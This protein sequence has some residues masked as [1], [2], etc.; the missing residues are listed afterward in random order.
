MSTQND[1]S[2]DSSNV[3]ENT[4][5]TDITCIGPK[6]ETAL[7]NMGVET[8]SDVAMLSGQ[9]MLENVASIAKRDV[10]AALMDAREMAGNDTKVT[11]TE[12]VDDAPSDAGVEV[13]ADIGSDDIMS[14]VDSAAT[15]ADTEPTMS[16]TTTA[17]DEMPE[18]YKPGDQTDDDE[19]ESLVEV[20]EFDSAR[21]FLDASPD[22]IPQPEDV[23]KVALV[24]GDEAFVT[25]DFSQA[26]QSQKAAIVQARL[27]EAEIDPDD[28]SIAA[29]GSGCGRRAVN[30]WVRQRMHNGVDTDARE[31]AVSNR[32]ASADDYR[33]RDERMLEWADALVVIADGDYVGGFINT[34]ADKRCLIDTPGDDEDDE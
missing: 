26:D 20:N 25:G 11:F 18:K 24:A 6:R 10:K 30:A 33:D 23:E 31:F 28:I 27:K 19:D 34:A 15:D 16:T 12:S 8:V 32:Y 2:N 4:D 29:V 14:E 3:R 9:A 21:G 5:L 17:D 1:A 22:P 7:N 13:P